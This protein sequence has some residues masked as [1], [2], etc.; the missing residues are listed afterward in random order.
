M[1]VTQGISRKVHLTAG[2]FAGLAVISVPPD[3]YAGKA[4]AQE[5]VFEMQDLPFNTSDETQE[6]QRHWEPI[7]GKHCIP[8]LQL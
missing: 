4:G 8:V 1:T 7:G 3:V 5:G 2:G 6:Q